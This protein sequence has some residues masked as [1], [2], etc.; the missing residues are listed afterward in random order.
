MSAVLLCRTKG[1]GCAAITFTRLSAATLP[2][3]CLVQRRTLNNI[4]PPTT[5]G[6]KISNFNQ[7]STST[8]PPQSPEE[9]EYKHVSKER[10]KESPGKI[11]TFI[12]KYGPIGVVTY[13][14]MYGLTLSAM[15]ILV[16]RGLIVSTDVISLL[17]KIGL[18]RFF[19]VNEINPKA[20]HFAVAWILTKF[21]EPIRFGLTLA[22]TPSIYRFITGRR[23]RDRDDDDDHKKQKDDEDDNNNKHKRKDD[24][25]SDKKHKRKQKEKDDD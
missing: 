20:G 1:V 19:D 11:T 4:L 7:F 23:A 6:C 12:K 13:F 8:Q 14:G 9:S 25:D 2:S 3:F 10:T 5:L 16:S 15:Y 22:V 18:D 17:Q 24:D 21:T